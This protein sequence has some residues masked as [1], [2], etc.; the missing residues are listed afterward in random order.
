[1]TNVQF[2]PTPFQTSALN[3]RLRP[4]GQLITDNL[5]TQWATTHHDCLLVISH[6]AALESQ[7]SQDTPTTNIALP[8]AAR[9]TKIPHIRWEVSGSAS[10]NLE[11]PTKTYNDE[12]QHT[13]FVCGGDST[14]HRLFA[15]EH[16]NLNFHSTP[17]FVSEHTTDWKYCGNM[18][19]H[20]IYV[21]C[22]QLRDTNAEEF[23]N[24]ASNFYLLYR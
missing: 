24:C 19:C 20:A 3:W 14:K 11:T 21:G 9:S 10:Q 7:A 23:S 13:K 17:C 1:M 22:H 4:L 15:R 6:T 18:L 2:E 5:S 16:T 12:F 8:T